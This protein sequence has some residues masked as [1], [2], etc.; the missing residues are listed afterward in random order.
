MNEPAIVE[1]PLNATQLKALERIVNADLDDAQAALFR[2]LDEQ[3]E[4]RLVAVRAEY[5]DQKMLA[6]ASVAQT[7]LTRQIEDDIVRAWDRLAEAHPKALLPRP[8]LRAHR[9]GG[10]VEPKGLSEA[11]RE[12]MVARNTLRSEV[13]TTIDAERRQLTRQVLL[14]GVTNLAA[15][16]LVND[17]PSAEDILGLVQQR[18][19]DAAKRALALLNPT[20]T[21]K[22][23]IK[24]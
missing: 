4:A 12:L 23:E 14:Q 3:Y 1:R 17:T 5:N 19:G 10:T 6:A 9:Q 16:E 20:N 8:A 15:A 21:T 22:K 13:A 18:L 2:Q 24:K 7:A 11:L